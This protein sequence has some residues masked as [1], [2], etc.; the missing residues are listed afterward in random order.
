MI[1]ADRA[2]AGAM[3]RQP[4]RVAAHAFARLADRGR[5]W[6]SRIPAGRSEGS[7][8]KSLMIERL[9]RQGDGVAADGAFVPFALPG[10]SVIASGKGERLQ[11]EIITGAS[12]LRVAPLCRHFGTCGGCQMQHLRPCA[13]PRLETQPGGRGAC[14]RGHRNGAAADHRLRTA[15]AASGYVHGHPL[16]RTAFSSGFRRSRRTGSRILRSARWCC[17]R[18]SSGLMICARWRAYSLRRKA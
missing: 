11:L 12:P 9:G 16:G 3:A 13:L 15:S 10:E 2:T 14:A 5:R 8:S 17:R 1:V 6:Q 4:A 7:M 18:S